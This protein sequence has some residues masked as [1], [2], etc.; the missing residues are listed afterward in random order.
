MVIS[1]ILRQPKPKL[2]HVYYFDRDLNLIETNY[3][4]NDEAISS[5]PNNIFEMIKI[6]CDLSKD[7]K[8]VR[9]DLYDLN[10][11]KMCLAN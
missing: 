9:A 1:V 11:E 6:A 5:L 4:G 8:S 7:F 3:K 2:V 10:D